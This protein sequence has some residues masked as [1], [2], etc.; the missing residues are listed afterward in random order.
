[1]PGRPLVCKN[2]LPEYARKTAFSQKIR[3][4][5]L[6]ITGIFCTFLHKYTTFFR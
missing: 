3:H 2:Y 4:K 5:T 6:P 1:M